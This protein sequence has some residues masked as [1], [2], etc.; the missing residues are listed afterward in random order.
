M[1][2][3]LP[4]FIKINGLRGDLPFGEVKGQGDYSN[5]AGAKIGQGVFEPP[6]AAKGRVAR[7]MLYFYVRY[8]DK[9][10]TNGAF[11]DA[12]WNQKVEM[13]LRWNRDYPPDANELRRNGLVA[14]FQGN[15]N[16]F[17]DKPGLADRIGEEALRRAGRWGLG[18]GLH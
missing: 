7:A 5:S 1:H 12:F 16:P 13:F 3:L 18:Y 2:H 11:G 8:C 6:N 17:I 4:T 15:R 10:I 14:G 9:N